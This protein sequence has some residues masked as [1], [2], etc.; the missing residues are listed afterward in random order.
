MEVDDDLEELVALKKREELKEMYGMLFIVSVAFFLFKVGWGA[1]AI[2]VAYSASHRSS[3][4]CQIERP[5]LCSWKFPSGR[6]WVSAV[7]FTTIDTS[8][9]AMHS[10]PL[11]SSQS[12]LYH[13]SRH[14][15]VYNNE[16]DNAND[17]TD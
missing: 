3:R 16:H 17:N 2:I 12:L 15:R 11:F 8:V 5:T 1:N 7:V 4:V 13:F 10:R 6:H 14:L 9:T